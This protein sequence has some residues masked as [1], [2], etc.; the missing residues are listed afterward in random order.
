MLSFAKSNSPASS[1]TPTSNKEAKPQTLAFSP[2]RTANKEAA[3]RPHLSTQ[4]LPEPPHLLRP[5]RDPHG[6]FRHAQQQKNLPSQLAP[7]SL[8]CPA[9]PNKPSCTCSPP[10]ILQ[11]CLATALSHAQILP[12]FHAPALEPPHPASPPRTLRMLC[13][14]RAWLAGNLTGNAATDVIGRDSSVH[15]L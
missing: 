5:I 13:R 7:Q 4:T 10:R 3:P 8:P 14:T 1:T 15:L 11:R 2:T 12:S 6:T 9:P